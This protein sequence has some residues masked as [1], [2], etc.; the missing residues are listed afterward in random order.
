M[1]E[2]DSQAGVRD[3]AGSGSPS[4]QRRKA[5]LVVGMSRSGTSLMTHI[6]HTLGAT[7][8]VDLIGPDRGNP[9]GH[10]EPRALVDINSQVLSHLGVAWDDPRPLPGSWFR[11]REAHD[12]SLRIMAR[13]EQDY[14][15]SQLLLIK[16]PRLCRLLPLYGEALEMLDIEATVVLQVRPV[17]EIARSLAERDGICP[18]LGGLLWLRSVIEAEWH[19]RHR[20]RIWLGFAQVT[21]GWHDSIR[22]VAQ[23]LDVNW[24]V[25]PAE[26]GER[27]AS[28]LRPRSEDAQWVGSD[29][30]LPA[31]PFVR[32]WEAIEAGIAGDEPTAQAGFDLVRASLNDADQLYTPIITDLMNRHTARLQAI[33][34]STC[35]RLTAPLRAMKQRAF[36]LG[37]VR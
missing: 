3:A 11:S 25:D 1:Q 18:A 33:R 13:I 2:N 37:G 12:Y 35:W 15:G 22:R 34:A 30:E 19:S 27:V 8:P 16:D 24:P 9:F 31:L 36:G 5:I 14:A 23:Q 4:R 6:L 21:A 10:W 29:T 32:A 17:A 20:R 28:L 26:A 7:L